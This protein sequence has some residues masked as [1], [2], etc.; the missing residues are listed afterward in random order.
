MSK[1]ASAVF[2][3]IVSTVFVVGCAPTRTQEATGEYVDDSAITAKVKTAL[4][5]AAD[6]KSNEIKVETFRGV[7]QLSGFVDNDAMA[8]R[9][10]RTAQNVEGVRSVRNDMHIRTSS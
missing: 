3:G 5:Q 6:V 10:V 8:D 7:V 4:L 2:A 9:A 1:L